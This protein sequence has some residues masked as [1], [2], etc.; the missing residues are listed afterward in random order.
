MASISGTELEA[1][2]AVADPRETTIYALCET[3]WTPRYVGKTVQPLRER[4][5]RHISSGRR[6]KLPIERWVKKHGRISMIVARLETVPAGGDWAAREIYWIKR[7]RDE[8]A[9]LLNLTDGGEGHLGRKK[10][11]DEIERTAEKLRKGKNVNCLNCSTSFWVKPHIIRGGD[12][13]YCSRSCYHSHGNS[14]PKPISESTREAARLATKARF[15]SQT[16]CKRGHLLSG[17]NLYKNRKGS[18][19]CKA[20]RKIHKKNFR[21]RP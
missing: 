18:R 16:H 15:A 17:D 8:G 3:D 21:A 6:A 4:I 12:G 14:K 7:F 19:V 2:R 5:T 11:K 13:K 10:S 9:N 1:I 20:C